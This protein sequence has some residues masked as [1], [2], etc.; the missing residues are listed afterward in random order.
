MAAEKIVA[1]EKPLDLICFV[2]L[3]ISGLSTMERKWRRG[4][5]F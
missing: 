3:E 2:A 5:S 4:N 1:Q